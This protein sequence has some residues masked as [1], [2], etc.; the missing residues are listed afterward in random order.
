M[1]R[2]FLYRSGY[3]VIVPDDV[4]KPTPLA[5][6][7]CD[8]VMSTRDDLIAYARWQCCEW[9]ERMWVQGKRD[10]WREGWRPDPDVVVA[11]LKGLGMC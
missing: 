3:T 10:R 11:T 4:P 5:C 6:P 2:Q 7:V 9:C 1:S 8:L